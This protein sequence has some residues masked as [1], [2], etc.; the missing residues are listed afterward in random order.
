MAASI[1]AYNPS[2]D[3]ILSQHGLKKQDLDKECSQAIRYETAI[4]ITEWKMFGY[5]FGIPSEKLHAIEVEN[6]TEEERRVALLSTW[7]KRE[8]RRATYYQLLS[9]L[10]NR[11]RRDLV[12]FLCGLIKQQLSQQKQSVPSHPAALT[13]PSG[14]YKLL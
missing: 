10:Y 12:D 1:E 9:A 14:N 3:E 13:T 7:Y 8:G 5:Y 6:K 2:L 11:R 4:K